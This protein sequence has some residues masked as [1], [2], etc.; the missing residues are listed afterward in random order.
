LAERGVD[1]RE[2]IG[3][4][5]D[6]ELVSKQRAIAVEAMRCAGTVAGQRA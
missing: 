4:R 5:L 6:A 1:E 3:A 2:R